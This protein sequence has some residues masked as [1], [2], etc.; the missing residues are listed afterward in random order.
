MSRSCGG[1][2]CA[3]QPIAPT[4]NRGH[5]PQP[6]M[7]ALPA[8]HVERPH[9]VGTH[10]AEGDRLAGWGP[11]C[12]PMS[13]TPDPEWHSISAP[14]PI[15]A[16]PS[17]AAVAPPI[18]TTVPT[19]SPGSPAGAP[20]AGPGLGAA[21]RPSEHPLEAEARC[22]AHPCLGKTASCSPPAA[23]SMPRSWL[24]R[25]KRRVAISRPRRSSAKVRPEPS[26]QI[27]RPKR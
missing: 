9:A 19:R 4:R 16:C 7:V 22:P 1:P 13:L 18:A 6:F 27:A 21:G 14:G 25:L 12:R 20:E 2:P 24:S 17:P 26:M 15:S 3:A 11:T 10:V 8:A 5:R 23:A